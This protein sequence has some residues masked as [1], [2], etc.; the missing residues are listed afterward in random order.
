MIV[1]VSLFVIGIDEVKQTL[2]DV[3]LVSDLGGRERGK[4]GKVCHV[5]GVL[6]VV[7]DVEHVDGVV[8]AFGQEVEHQRRFVEGIGKSGKEAV[9]DLSAGDVVYSD[10]GDVSEE[11]GECGDV[12]ACRV[13]EETLVDSI[14]V[15]VEVI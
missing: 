3:E 8:D 11:V 15:F 1:C 13:G 4:D 9:G 10:I 14:V 2:H 12:A 7:V 5:D 6:V